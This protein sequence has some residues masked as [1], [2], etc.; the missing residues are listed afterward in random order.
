MAPVD[1]PVV[2]SILVGAGFLAG[3]PLLWGAIVL[4]LSYVGGWQ[5]LA[6]RYATD[7]P[8]R[9]KAFAWSTAASASSTTTT[10]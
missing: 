1:D 3:F 9:G 5:R 8:P 2:Q 6:A 7:K 4:L 10:A